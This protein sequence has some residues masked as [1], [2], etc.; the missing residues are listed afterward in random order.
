MLL[1]TGLSFPNSSSKLL[2]MDDIHSMDIDMLRDDLM[3]A[4]A[5]ERLEQEERDQLARSILSLSLASIQ[6]NPMFVLYCVHLST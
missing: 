3:D 6:T 5:A 1:R 2:E 4:A